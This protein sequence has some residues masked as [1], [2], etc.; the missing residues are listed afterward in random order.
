MIQAIDRATKILTVLS[1]SPNGLTISQLSEKTGLSISTA[2]RF[3][4]ALMD[5]ELVVHN[6]ATKHYRIG[7]QLLTLASPFLRG[8]RIT[9]IARG[10]L[11]R[12]SEEWG[13]LVYLAL[14]EN[15]R[16]VCVDYATS[17]HNNSTQFYVQ[18]GSHMPLNAAASAKVILCHLD[19]QD[20][21]DRLTRAMPFTRF[22][23]HTLLDLESLQADLALCRSRGFAICDEEMEIGMAAIS[24]PIFHYSGEPIA[25]LTVTAVKSPEIFSPSLIE[26]LKA[27]ARG[28]SRELGY[29]PKL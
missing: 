1:A 22:T 10:Y 14:F 24:A 6:P 23:E 25:S 2:H 11:T 21:K 17:F 13:K 15:G 27:A 26:S 16:T 7:V 12:L 19:E 18:M 29:V 3:L 5:N 28:I 20:I 9:G 8:N 4:H